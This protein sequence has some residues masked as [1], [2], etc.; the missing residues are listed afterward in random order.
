MSQQ[1]LSGRV[2]SDLGGAELGSG[3]LSGAEVIILSLPL[4]PVSL[5]LCFRLHTNSILSP[6]V[7]S[8]GPGGSW[9]F[10]NS[11]TLSRP[12]LQPRGTD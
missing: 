10:H 11:W 2:W 6:Q 5:C 8:P 7:G 3:K 4:L 1:P 12:L 9:L